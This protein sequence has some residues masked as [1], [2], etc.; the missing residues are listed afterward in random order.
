MP[1]AIRTGSLWPERYA[2]LLYFALVPM[3][4]SSTVTCP[5]QH[6]RQWLALHGLTDAVQDEP[7]GLGGS[8]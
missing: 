6:A 2:S 1:G 4:V 8:P 5:P 7:G 3:K